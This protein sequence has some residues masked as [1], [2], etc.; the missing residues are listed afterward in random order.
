MESYPLAY[1]L[2]GGYD[3]LILV[4][5]Q[6]EA[7]QFEWAWQ[8]P[9]KSLAVKEAAARIPS[10][11]RGLKK[12]FYLLF[13]MLNCDKWSSM[14]L[15]VQFLSS[16]YIDYRKGCPGL[17]PHMGLCIAP[18]DTL[19]MNVEE[20]DSELDVERSS[21]PNFSDVE[22]DD[23][24]P[25]TENQ[26]IG[27]PISFDRAES[28]DMSVI[29]E[30]AAST[31]FSTQPLVNAMD[32]P[33]RQEKIMKDRRKAVDFPASDDYAIR[34]AHVGDDEWFRSRQVPASSVEAS[35]SVDLDCILETSPRIQCR[36]KN[37]A[38]QDVNKT[39][40]KSVLES[41]EVERRSSY[42]CL[43][44]SPPRLVLSPSPPENGA[45]EMSPFT[46]LLEQYSVKSPS[47]LVKRC[48]QQKANAHIPVHSDSSASIR[49]LSSEGFRENVPRTPPCRS[50]VV[51]VIP[52]YTPIAASREVIDLTD[53][54]L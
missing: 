25:P 52:D 9:I 32:V 44:S 39:K 33:G 41:G 47:T 10:S 24:D 20:A 23:S 51:V 3:E 42:D 2:D 6:V 30:A 13:T 38:V 21:E 7:L 34:K 31:S 28:P 5:F 50:R 37:V 26:D 36:S 1:F 45:S 40:V 54:P 22:Q 29:G 16:K 18:V 17:P 48:L 35:V 14:D 4:V 43:E 15:N 12:Q 19:P 8:H 49:N 27:R 53:S 46:A 11:V